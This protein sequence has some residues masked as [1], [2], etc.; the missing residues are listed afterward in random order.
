MGRLA[1]TV[2]LLAMAMTAPASAADLGV[3]GALF[4]LAETD[5]LELLQARLK[6]AQ[7]SGRVDRLNHE[8]AARARR[9]IER[10]PAVAGLVHTQEPRSW[11]FDPT[12]VA[13]KDIADPNGRVFVHTGDR[14][15][16]L[17]RMATFDRVM[18]FIDGDDP[19]QV[20]FG[21]RALHTYGAVRTRVILV[22]GAPLELMKREKAS[23]YFDQGGTL[24]DRFGLR[25]VPA[26]IERSGDVLKISEVKP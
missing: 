10:P 8:F 13:A 4:P 3:R 23:F 15:N 11:T 20:A 5:V 7:A 18:V 6:A 9:S 17:Q 19:D 2:W 1:I 26:V 24:C 16:P 22:K 14:I 25:Q 21:L 12:I